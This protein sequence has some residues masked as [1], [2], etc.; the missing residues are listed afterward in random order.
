MS[1]RHFWT[2]IIGSGAIKIDVGDF[3][4]AT[5]HFHYFS[6]TKTLQLYTI[7]LKMKMHT[8]FP[9][10]NKKYRLRHK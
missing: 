1:I 10:F 6:L 9:I 2:L 4:P 5:V 3:E 8:S 7:L